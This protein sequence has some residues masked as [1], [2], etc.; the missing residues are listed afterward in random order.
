MEQINN[1]PSATEEDIII[2]EKPNQPSEAASTEDNTNLQENQ[3]ANQ[4]KRRNLLHEECLGFIPNSMKGRQDPRYVY[5]KFF[6]QYKDFD[7][8][9]ED[10]LNII[11][12]LDLLQQLQILQISNP[13]KSIDVFFRTEDAADMFVKHHISIR[14]KPIPFIRKA[15]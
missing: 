1:T 13:N 3:E 6:K 12:E 15:K 2:N 10:F 11:E 7:Y 14:G 5:A 4:I 8:T 9:N